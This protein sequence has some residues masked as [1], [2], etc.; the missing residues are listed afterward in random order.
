MGGIESEAAMLGIPVTLSLPEVVGCELTGSIS[1]FATSIDVVLS[2]TKVRY[3]VEYS[4]L[5]FLFF[6][7][8]TSSKT[9]SYRFIALSSIALYYM[10]IMG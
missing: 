4:V 5:C 1:P 3:V 8:V 2:I 10:V 7:R 6:V 9:C